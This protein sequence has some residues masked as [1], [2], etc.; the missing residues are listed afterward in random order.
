MGVNSLP[1]TVTQQHHGCNLNPGP[2]AR[3]Q[4]ANHSATEPP[5]LIV[6]SQKNTTKWAIL[7]CTYCFLG[8][9][10]NVAGFWS[11][12]LL[13]NANETCTKTQ[14]INHRHHLKIFCIFIVITIVFECQMRNR[15]CQKVSMS[16]AW[17]QI[18]KVI[19]KEWNQKNKFAHRSYTTVGLK[20]VWM[21][22]TV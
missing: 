21:H 4:H 9:A 8:V 1:K 10:F 2:S 22:S 6:F 12:C 15:A 3:V 5:L 7:Q 13:Q 14:S 17:I 20:A 18:R 11:H 16:T 19:R